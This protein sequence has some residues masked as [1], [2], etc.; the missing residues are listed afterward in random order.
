MAALL[1][2]FESSDDDTAHI[3]DPSEASH[4]VA[5]PRISV[6]E[7]L[8]TRNGSLERELERMRLLLARVAGRVAQLPDRSAAAST[9]EDE[10]TTAGYMD[11][12]SLERVK[13]EKLLDRR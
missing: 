9:G 10:A 11:I 13:V 2:P 7:N 3:D 5:R 8:V 12:D 1:A 4:T 6:Q